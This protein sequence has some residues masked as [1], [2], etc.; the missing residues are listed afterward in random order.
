MV[1]LINLIC[2]DVLLLLMNPLN[3]NTT[4]FTY[5]TWHETPAYTWITGHA[6][7][8]YP[9]REG[10]VERQ[11]GTK[12]VSGDVSS[13]IKQMWITTLVVGGNYCALF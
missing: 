12:G 2:L 3:R 13:K 1:L 7:G 6:R 9:R 11:V 5:R 10:G 8:S 4:P